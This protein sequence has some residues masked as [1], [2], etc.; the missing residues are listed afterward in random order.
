[1][2]D[3]QAY[4]KCLLAMT[5]T[6]CVFIFYLNLQYDNRLN[7]I[8]QNLQMQNKSDFGFITMD[9][10]TTE[11]STHPILLSEKKWPEQETTASAM[12]SLSPETSALA[13]V[14]KANNTKKHPTAVISSI[15][16]TH[17]PVKQQQYLLIF[18]FLNK[19][20]LNNFIKSL[21]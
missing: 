19:N 21:P 8:E 14:K 4:G 15:L 16:H 5:P 6:L 12:A 10:K 11:C 13:S 7:D 18:L 1:M 17:M 9:S 2:L 20:I 3:G